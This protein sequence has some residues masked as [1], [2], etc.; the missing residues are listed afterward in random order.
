MVF[1]MSKAKELVVVV[2]GL[3][4]TPLTMYRAERALRDAG[5]AVANWGYNSLRGNLHEQIAR[6]GSRVHELQ[7]YEKVHGVGHSQGGLMLRGIFAKNA[8]Q[9]PLGRLVMQGTPNQGAGIVKRHSWL[10]R[11]GPLNHKIVHDL[12][13]G[14]DAIRKL[15]VPK[16]EIGIIAG[17][18]RF[19][20]INPVTWINTFTLGSEPHDGTVEAR[21][22][23][24]PGMADYLE[25]PVNHLALPFHRD[26]IDASIRFIQTGKFKP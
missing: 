16:M 6:L 22:T 3:V 25:L 9:L 13:E 8:G 18:E 1:R 24:L 7:G 12:G 5:Y 23:H 14:S 4:N 15:P 10:F 19:H 21:N 2:H 20:P 17:V 11:R 26:V